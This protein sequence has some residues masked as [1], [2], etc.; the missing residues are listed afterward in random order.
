MYVNMKKRFVA[1]SE[2]Q[3]LTGLSYKTIMHMI[4]SG[5]LP[6]VETES[7]QYRIDTQTVSK[8]AGVTN[9]KLDEMQKLLKA[10]CKQFNTAV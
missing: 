9:E 10:L 7:G 3:R 5:Q 4:R 6:H 2:Y 8:D 1:V